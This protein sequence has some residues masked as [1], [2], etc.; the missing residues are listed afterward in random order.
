MSSAKKAFFEWHY[1]WY[2]SVV[3]RRKTAREISDR[4]CMWMWRRHDTSSPW[5]DARGSLFGWWTSLTFHERASMTRIP[6][7]LEK[8]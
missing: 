7:W 6:S 8:T 1:Q 3:G 5:P 4:Q 2:I